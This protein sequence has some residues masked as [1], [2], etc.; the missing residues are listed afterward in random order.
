V[1]S[2]K[3][4]DHVMACEDNLTFM[5][6]LSAG[7]M[8]LIVTSPPYNIGKSYESRSITLDSYIDSQAQVIAE[9]V[10][11]LHPQGSICWQVG[12]HVQNGEIFPLDIVLY[13]I[14]RAHGLKLRNRVI[15]HFEDGLHCS[16]RLSGRHEAIL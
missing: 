10:R 1:S 7:S 2:A 4:P 13:P 12:N 8:K 11:L 5:R 15:W 6:P 14:F 16:K 9:C 3:G